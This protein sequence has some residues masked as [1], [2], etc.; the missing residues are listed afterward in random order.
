[1]GRLHKKGELVVSKLRK[2]RL[3]KTR[4]VEPV[5]KLGSQRQRREMQ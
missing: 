1:M 3:R 4:A 2:P 5:W